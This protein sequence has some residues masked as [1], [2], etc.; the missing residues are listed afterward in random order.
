MLSGKL[1]GQILLGD[2]IFS[3]GTQ[4]HEATTL[5]ERSTKYSDY[6]DG[7]WKVAAFWIVSISAIQSVYTT[8]LLP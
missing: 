6:F 5:D 2:I 8:A 3:S 1:G 7:I 4:T